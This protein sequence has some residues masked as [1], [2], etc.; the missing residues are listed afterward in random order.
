VGILAAKRSFIFKYIAAKRRYMFVNCLAAR[1]EFG[2]TIRS[3][4]SF[5]R[6]E[7]PSCCRL[8][9]QV[10][11]RACRPGPAIAFFLVIAMELRGCASV[12]KP[13]RANYTAIGNAHFGRPPWSP[14]AA[15][16]KDVARI[17]AT[18]NQGPL[19]VQEVNIKLNQFHVLRRFTSTSRL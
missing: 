18:G 17:A 19:A 10:S 13:P 2:E 8:Q 16:A 11:E 4:L 6:S 14:T 12:D 3:P 7:C 15:T 9:S 5:L 1:R